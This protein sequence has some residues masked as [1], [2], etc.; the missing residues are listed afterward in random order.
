[1]PWHTGND[2][3]NRRMLVEVVRYFTTDAMARF[4]DETVDKLEEDASEIA[5]YRTGVQVITTVYGQ[6]LA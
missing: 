3:G 5:V 4:I 1:M 2:V 6:S